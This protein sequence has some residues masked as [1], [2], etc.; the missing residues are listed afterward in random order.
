MKAKNSL[1]P[2][3]GEIVEITIESLAYFGGRGVGRL[4]GVV[5]FVPGVAPED[6]W[7]VRIT[8]VKSR[9][10]EAEAVELLQAGAARREPPCP[11]AGRCGGCSW[12]HV[13]YRVQIE[14]KE[15][16][17][18][19]ALRKIAKTQSL[20]W[21]PFI[22]APEEFHYRNRIQI[23]VREGRRGFF[24]ARSRD[25]V[26]FD[27]CWIAEEKL[28]QRLA[29]L[30]E[31]ELAGSKRLELAVQTDGSVRM[32]E[33]ERDPEAALFSQVNTAQNQQLIQAMLAAIQS[34]PDWILDLYCGSGNLTL[35][36]KEKFPNA[37]IVGVELS[38]SSIERA[39][40]VAPEIGWEAGDVAR[41]LSNLRP[42]S[43]A[44]LIVMDPPRLG[45]ATEVIEQV[46]RQSPR[47]IVYISCNPTTFARDAER[48][49]A[50]SRYRI[51]SVQGLDMFPQTEH[52]EL[53]CSLRAAT[54]LTS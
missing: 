3:L 40:S 53:I 19:D 17:L 44:G 21:R 5:I 11:V 43:G 4:Q 23:Q 14:Q 28:N 33:N 2:K 9:F 47:Q 45:C 50:D 34:T 37:K 36:L 32:M 35:P 20:N 49:I 26:E 13:Q 39:R 54:L 24:A 25:L 30:K 22:P 18:R 41:I 29:E 46:L 52:V 10:L 1:T 6:R 12:Q 31:H 38:R 7:R 51:E 16:I 48:L 8:A 42:D 15:K 27:Q